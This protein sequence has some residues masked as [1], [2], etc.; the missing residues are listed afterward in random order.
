VVNG[1]QP[2]PEFLRFDWL[3]GDTVLVRDRRVP[4]QG[5]LDPSASPL[6]R[7]R[8]EVA[9]GREGMRRAVVRGLIGDAVVAEGSA[10]ATLAPGRWTAIEVTL[11]GRPDTGVPDAGAPDVPANDVAM[12]PD[13]ASD[14]PARDVAAGDTAADA[15]GD[16]GRTPDAALDAPA[17]E[18]GPSTFPCGNALVVVGGVPGDSDLALVARLVQLGC[19][20]VLRDATSLTS[21]DATGRSLALVSETVSPPQARGKLKNVT[22]GVINM[23]ASLLSDFGFNGNVTGTDWAQSPSE[24]E[25][26]IGEASHPLAAGLTGTVP[27]FTATAAAA[28]AI[29][30]GAG[31]IRIAAVPSGPTHFM[32]FAFDTGGKMSGTFVAPGRRVAFPLGRDSVLKLN[33]SGWALFDAAVR[34][35]AGH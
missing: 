4:D 2:A 8:I 25:V 28:W 22:I 7:I 20:V 30:D 17:G 24:L 11:G 12:A 16:A 29:P 10:T 33:A 13:L 26:M 3:D 32:V 15:A 1:A 27:I 14:S 35:A 5:T 23:Q 18:G 31:A 21:A 19:T 9:N 6:A 34:W